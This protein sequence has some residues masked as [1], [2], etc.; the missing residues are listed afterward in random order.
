MILQVQ[1]L[2]KKSRRGYG[3]K[4]L[5]TIQQ[6][7]KDDFDDFQTQASG[8][9]DLKSRKSVVQSEKML[10]FDDKKS[11]QSGKTNKTRINA[12]ERWISIQLLNQNVEKD[13]DKISN[14]VV[15]DEHIDEERIKKYFKNVINEQ[16]FLRNYE[17]IK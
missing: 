13:F 6:S 3:D 11:R 1:A 8:R 7:G 15:N 10:D 4:T 2:Q 9:G 5:Q 17:R 12:K 14:F 16:N